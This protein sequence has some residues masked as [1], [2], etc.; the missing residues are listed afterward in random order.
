VR[1]VEIDT[2]VRGEFAENV[3]RLPFAPSDL[4]AIGR[5]D[6]RVERERAEARMVAAHA[7]AGKLPELEK[8]N[9]RDKIAKQLG[10]SARNYVKARDVVEAAEAEPDKFGHLVEELD[11]YRGV[12]RAYRALHCARDEQRVL[13]LQ[14]HVGKFRTLVVDVPWEYDTDW[15]GRGQPQYALMKRDEA[16]ALPV[17]SWAEDDSHIYVWATNAN[18]PLAV[19]CL[20]AWGFVHKAVLTWV[21]PAPFGLGKYFRGS[22][23]HV[24]FGVRGTLMTRSTSIPTHFEAPRG[25]HSEKPERFYE[26]VRAASYPPYGEAFQR[27]ARRSLSN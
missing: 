26:I 14:P 19:E 17:A 24:L 15:L 13:S 2:V 20:A 8:G 25:E 3:D 21:K 1:I 27:K 16:L 10:M 11:R 6:E 18:L 4:V 5:E 9:A 12:D 7:S 23:E 22:T